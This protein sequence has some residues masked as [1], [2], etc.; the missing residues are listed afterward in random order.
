M[1]IVTTAIFADVSEDPYCPTLYGSDGFR[2]SS[3]VCLAALSFSVVYEAAVDD[4]RHQ[5]RQHRRCCRRWRV[6]RGDYVTVRCHCT[7]IRIYLVL[8]SYNVSLLHLFWMKYDSHHQMRWLNIE[9][10][11][12]SSE[13]DVEELFYTLLGG[14]LLLKVAAIYSYFCNG[15]LS[16]AQNV[17]VLNLATCEDRCW[18]GSSLCGSGRE[19][20][21]EKI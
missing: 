21:S 20:T 4:G 16:W 9:C 11:T 5:D 6:R 12:V 3:D 13:L 7:R 1:L 17:F 19:P 8:V 14:F 15:Y 18:N 10:S 2:N